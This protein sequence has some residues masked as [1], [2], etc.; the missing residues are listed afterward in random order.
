MNVPGYWWKCYLGSPL[1]PFFSRVSFRS[2]LILVGFYH[3]LKGTTFVFNGGWLP[4]VTPP[5]WHVDR[6]WDPRWF[7]QVET[8]TWTEAACGTALLAMRGGWIRWIRMLDATIFVGWQWD[9]CNNMMCIYIYDIYIFCL[10]RILLTYIDRFFF[11]ID[12]MFFWGVLRREHDKILF[13]AV[14]VMFLY[15]EPIQRV[16]RFQWVIFEDC[17]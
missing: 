16:E 4:E 6:S 10:Y 11:S 3:L 9:D 1:P 17:I 5:R 12:C 7:P 2:T 14:C 15:L 8:A 13:H